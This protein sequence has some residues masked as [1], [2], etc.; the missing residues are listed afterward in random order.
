M[1]FIYFSKLIDWSKYA[2]A[3]TYD[4]DSA[5]RRHKKREKNVSINESFTIIIYGRQT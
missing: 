4:D 1:H 3:T 2:I 5:D